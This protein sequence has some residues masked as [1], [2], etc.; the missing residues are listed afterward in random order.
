MSHHVRSWSNLGPPPS[1]SSSSSY[2]P[3]HLPVIKSSDCTDDDLLIPITLPHG[4]TLCSSLRG[5]QQ[6]HLAT[7]ALLWSYSLAT[8]SFYSLTCSMS[9]EGSTS[10]KVINR[11]KGHA[12]ISPDGYGIWPYPVNRPSITLVQKVLRGCLCSSQGR[13]T[14]KEG[15][16]GR[17]RRRDTGGELT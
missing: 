7:L 12:V 10:N 9:R 17:R 2:N 16:D 3:C 13:H 11:L 5:R 14:A 4:P 1:S 8:A 15:D 6:S